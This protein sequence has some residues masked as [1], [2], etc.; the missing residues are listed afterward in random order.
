MAQVK[1]LVK[2]LTV[3]KPWRVLLSFSLPMLGSVVFQQIYNIADSMIAGQFVGEDALAAVGAS[4]PITMIFLA[5]AMGCNIGCSVV[6]S[7]LFGG[8][9]YTDMKTAINTSYIFSLVISGL[10]TV[11]GLIFCSFLMKLV[12]TPDNIFSDSN[13]YLQIYIAGTVFLFMYNVCTGIFNA[14]GDSKTP[15]YFLI[16]SSVGN[17]ILDLIFVIVLK[18]GVSGVAWATFIAQGTASVL[19]F[20]VLFRRISKIKTDKKAKIF[21]FSMLRRISVIAVPS[22]LQQSFISVGNMF[23]Q[24][25]IN[26]YGSTVIAGYSAGIKLN[27]FT[28]TSIT[29]V[30]NGL[31][32][33]TAQNV[34]ACRIDRVKKGMRSG[35]VMI[36][37]VAI[38]FTVLYF[39]FGSTFLNIFM[40][41]NASREAIDIGMG[42]LKTVSPFYLIV[43]IKLIA[44]AVLRGAGAMGSFMIATFL[45]LIIRVVLAFVLSPVYGTTG[46]WMSWPIGWI[47]GMICSVI[48]YFSGIWKPKY[49]RKEN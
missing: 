21:S 44:D 38:P 43:A 23:V 10:L 36:S 42:F 31:S 8:K 49:L 29:T 16:A 35:L 37:F 15:L 39:F 20:F 17:I 40:D 7:Q 11:L 18:M 9:R 22:I 47:I 28:L 24:G 25:I 3:G 2:D 32:S 4:Y 1:K 5:V 34:G 26:S 45:D 13:L 6:I 46:I 27:T 33:F 41:S 19:S 30:A 48:F 14:L 12:N